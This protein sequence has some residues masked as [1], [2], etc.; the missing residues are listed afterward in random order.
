MKKKYVLL[1]FIAGLLIGAL[2]CWGGMT[3]PAKL[4]ANRSVYDTCK[5]GKTVDLDGLLMKRF[6]FLP[7]NRVVVVCLSSAD[8]EKVDFETIN[9]LPQQYENLYLQY[10][11]DERLPYDFGLNGQEAT[12]ELL[13]KTQPAS[14]TCRIGN[15]SAKALTPPCYLLTDA[16]GVLLFKTRDLAELCKQLE[17]T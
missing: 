9:A 3:L 4:A 11:M 2:L 8:A 7:E 13:A 6:D 10:L 12:E 17:N 5:V 16:N 15:Y 14:L 1:V